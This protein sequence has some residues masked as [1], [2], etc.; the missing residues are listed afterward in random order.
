MV[1]VAKVLHM[2]CRNI[3]ITAAQRI[4]NTFATGCFWVNILENI[5]D[6]S[7]LFGIACCRVIVGEL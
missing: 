3:A 4:C 6:I 5:L 7:M 1:T 2:R